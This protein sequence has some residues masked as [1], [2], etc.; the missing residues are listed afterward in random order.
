MQN[1]KELLANAMEAIAKI[2]LDQ[3]SSAFECHL[4]LALE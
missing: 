3:E 2:D 4:K 1:N